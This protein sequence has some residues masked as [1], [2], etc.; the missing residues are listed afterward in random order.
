MRAIGLTVILAVL[1]MGSAAA[2]QA[3]LSHS[4]FASCA[5]SG[6]SM[7]MATITPPAPEHPR[8]AGRAV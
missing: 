5:P 6:G 7:T 3:Q 8:L 1:T 4:P 2:Q